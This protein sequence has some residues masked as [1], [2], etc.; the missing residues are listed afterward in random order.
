MSIENTA[1]SD[2]DDDFRDMVEFLDE[3]DIFM[4]EKDIVLDDEW[5]RPPPP[6]QLRELPNEGFTL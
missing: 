6:H 1:L 3:E 2:P 5:D 4:R